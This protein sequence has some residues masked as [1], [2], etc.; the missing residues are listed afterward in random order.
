MFPL[1]EES[2]SLTA[3][4]RGRRQVLSFLWL[5]PR[6]HSSRGKGIGRYADEVEPGCGTGR[7]QMKKEHV[8]A[9]N[10][11]LKAR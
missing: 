7:L 9:G 6:F 8:L 5:K 11:K 4:P 2:I 10:V 3:Q 1:S